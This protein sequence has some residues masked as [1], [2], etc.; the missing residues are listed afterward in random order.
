M[1]DKINSYFNLLKK[2]A[3]L[4][5]KNKIQKIDNK[6][7]TLRNS[8]VNHIVNTFRSKMEKLT[9]MQNKVNFE[10]EKASKS[11]KS[12]EVRYCSIEDNLIEKTVKN[13]QDEKTF[14]SASKSVSFTKIGPLNETVYYHDNNKIYKN[15]YFG[16]DYIDQ[17]KMIFIGNSIIITYSLESFEQSYFEIE[18]NT[19]SK[20]SYFDGNQV[21]YYEFDFSDIF[22]YFPKTLEN[23]KFMDVCNNR[24]PSS[25]KF[26][27]GIM[28][29]GKSFMN[30]VNKQ[31]VILND[32]DNAEV[33]PYFDEK[34]GKESKFIIKNN[35]LSKIF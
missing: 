34:Y 1:T 18:K 25:I 17:N 23:I 26:K 10:F 29:D 5:A 30:L 20:Q 32:C 27:N 9:A 31:C 4:V 15:F 2:E 24:I 16:P 35:K 13:I 28:Y 8:K 33:F 19:D 21:M 11:E 14:Y 12:I 7:S 6:Y 3:E 22:R